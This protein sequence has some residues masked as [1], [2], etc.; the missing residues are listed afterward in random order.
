MTATLS[1]TDKQQRWERCRGCIFRQ[2]YNCVWRVVEHTRAGAAPISRI[3]VCLRDQDW[4]R[5]RRPR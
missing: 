2:R 1:A 5:Q 3:A 4:G